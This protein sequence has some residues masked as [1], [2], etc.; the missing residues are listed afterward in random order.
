MDAR[1]RADPDA[2]P[3]ASDDP[4]SPQLSSAQPASSAQSAHGS[5]SGTEVVAW[6]IGRAATSG[7]AAASPPAPEPAPWQLRTSATEVCTPPQLPHR[8]SG[9][10]RSYHGRVDNLAGV[11]A[12]TDT[13]PRVLLVAPRDS[14]RLGAHLRAVDAVGAIAL[15]ATDQPGAIAGSTIAVDLADP[16]TAARLA[17]LRPDAVL[18]TDAETLTLAAEIGQLLGLERTNPVAAVRA[19]TD[20]AAQRQAVHATATATDRGSGARVR[21]PAFVVVQP[22]D[23]PVAA[24]L[25]LGFPVVVKPISL[26]ASRGVLRA[27]DPLD[28][29]A[30]AGLVRS[31]VL[32]GEPVLVEQFVAGGELALDGILDHGRFALLAAFDKP[33]APQ[34]PTF[35]E[36]FLVAPARVPA[37]TQAAA[38]EATEAACAALGLRHG[39]VH[40][41]FRIDGAGRPW[42]LELAA[43]TI[44]G[45]CA[46]LLHTADG[47]PVEEALV[48]LALGRPV[49]L[50]PQPGA[51][52]VCM[53]AVP[54]DGTVLSVGRPDAARAVPGIGDV[55]IDVQPGDRVTALPSGGAYPGFVF[56]TGPTAD[57]V[58]ATLRAAVGHLT[59]VVDPATASSAAEER[60]LSVWPA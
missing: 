17:A 31:M 60:S 18:A 3:A 54:R 24:A 16:A 2:P 30:A 19:S 4:S 15:V 39:P 52:G 23:D 57:D 8:I 49:D 21:Q 45:R 37:A 55:W 43:R 44:G 51:M 28:T 22:G 36:T 20:K 27:E 41:E 11:P 48:R 26:T 35:P 12:A 7:R 25:Q 42:F 47:R 1:D 53:L 9:I 46:Q 32:P 50:R 33:D 59:L 6:A 29:H 5:S 14:Y 58:E 13:S 10:P 38:V 56:A 34:G 40:A